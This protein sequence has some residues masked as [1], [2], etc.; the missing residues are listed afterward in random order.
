MAEATISLTQMPRNPESEHIIQLTRNAVEQ[1]ERQYPLSSIRG[2]RS[3]A[4]ASA[5]PQASHTPGGHRRQQQNPRNQ[6]E[7]EVASGQRPRY[8]S[9]QDHAQ[10]LRLYSTAINV[11]GGD[12]TTK[13]FYFPMVLEPAPL[14]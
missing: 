10:W 14:T 12:I 5:A 13:V 6:E 7:Q 3:R 8:D 4:T 11:A 2:T 1:L 9:K